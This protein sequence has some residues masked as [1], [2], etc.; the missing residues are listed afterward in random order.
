LNLIVA[1]KKIVLFSLK[2]GLI[3][4]LILTA[5]VTAWEWIENPGGIFHNDNG[6]NWSFV[7]DTAISWFVPTFLNVTLISGL[8]Y[9]VFLISKRILKK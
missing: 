5:L 6:T 2:F 1:I 4:A 9:T 7:Y 3:T 8:V